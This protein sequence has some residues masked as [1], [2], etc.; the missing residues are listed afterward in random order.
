MTYKT[1]LIF[2]LTITVI[3]SQLFA[4]STVKDNLIGNWMGSVKMGE[5]SPRL[6]F[7]IVKDIN[8]SLK[9]T[10]GSPDKGIKGIPVNNILTAGDSVI[11]EINA[12][13]AIFKGLLSVDKKSI[14]GIWQEEDSKQLITLKS[15][16]AE[17]IEVSKPNKNIKYN[18]Q[19]SNEYFNFYLEDKDTSVITNLAKTLNANYVQLTTIMKAKFSEKIDVIIY[20]DI[21]SFH[22]AINLESAPD[23]VVG[24]AGKNELKMVSPINPGTVHNYESLMKAIVH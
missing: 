3:Q 17:E 19:F 11:F 20:P 9:G 18:L 14:S 1:A 13:S 7:E 10:V 8:N 2:L 5:D 4:Q 16:A 23:W 12:A 15:V 21:N 6:V 24:A 22:K